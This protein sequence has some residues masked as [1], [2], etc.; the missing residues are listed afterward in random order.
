MTL[1][2]VTTVFPGQSF[3]YVNRSSEPVEIFTTDG[4]DRWDKMQAEIRA[5]V[6]KR[7]GELADKIKRYV[8]ILF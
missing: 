8:D 6:D 5:E 2:K 7:I 1:T 3:G 4:R